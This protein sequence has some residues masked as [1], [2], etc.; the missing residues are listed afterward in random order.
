MAVALLLCALWPYPSAHRRRSRL[1][2]SVILAYTLA[3]IYAVAWSVGRILVVG[4]HPI[5][6]ADVSPGR[7]VV[8]LLGSG[9]HT[10]V[11]WHNDEFSVLDRPGASRVLEAFR[12]FRDIGADWIVSSGGTHTDDPARAAGPIMR[13]ALVQL[14]VPSARILLESRSQN[15]RDE[16]VL[17]AAMM[18]PLQVE[19]VILVTSD[20]HMRRSLAT[21]RA[22]GLAPIPAIAR[23]HYA[24]E[25]W[26]IWLLP[27]GAGLEMSGAFAH[28]LFG[29]VYYAARGWARYR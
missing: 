29:M 6:R 18:K 20:L 14:G 2:L 1:L 13:D 11:D 4:L 28:E 5:G 3:S 12:V 24:D 8:V 25:S 10:V 19:N 17:V 9:T 27:G 23:H 21:F 16:A 7:N 22:V 26:R 15:T